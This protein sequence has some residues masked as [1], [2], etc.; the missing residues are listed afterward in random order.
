MFAPATVYDPHQWQRFPLAKATHVPNRCNQLHMPIN[1]ETSIRPAVDAHWMPSG[2]EPGLASI[3]IPTFNRASLLEE[4]LASAAGQTYRPLE[5]IVVD[6]GSTDDTPDLVPHWQDRFKDEAGLV[7]RYFRQPNSGVGSARNR[8]LIE[9]RGE[10]IQFLDSDDLL[11]PQKLSRQIECLRRYPQ[12]GYVV[13]DGKKIEAAAAWADVPDGGEKVMDSSEYYCARRV[14]LMM[15][16]VYRRATCCLAGPIAEDLRLGEDEEFNLRV[17]LATQRVVYLP[18]VLSAL[19]KHAGPRLTDAGRNGTSG[20]VHF[21]RMYR[22]MIES[23]AARDR[24]KDARLVSA[25]GRCISDNIQAALKAGCREL[26]EEGIEL[27]LRLPVEPSR[28]LRIEIFRI[29][30]LLPA[31]MLPRLRSF[32]IKLRRFFKSSNAPA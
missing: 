21:F 24:L 25:L 19:R 17:L 1:V 28:R 9:S 15:A 10:Y 23:A 12:C 7:I 32:L 22:R 5:I 29:L 18:G 8:G 20:L 16:G 2:G 3:I 13:S 6:D 27:C 31:G 30:N 11:H 14:W 26:A 4:A